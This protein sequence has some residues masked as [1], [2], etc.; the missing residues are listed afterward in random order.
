M[1]VNGKHRAT[2]SVPAGASE[3]AIR[4]AAL[5]DPDVERHIGGKAVRKV[6]VVQ[7]GRLVNV[8]AG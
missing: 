5:S 8:V 2:L 6:I 7:G 1:Q 4:E 3:D